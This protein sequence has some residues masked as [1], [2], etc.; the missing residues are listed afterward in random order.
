MGI[1]VS[2][3][4][5]TFNRVNFLEE[6][7]NSVLVQTLTNWEC[8]VVDDG[9]TDG[10][11][12][13][14]EV[15]LKRDSRFKYLQRPI[16]R[17]KG[18]SSCRNIGL[19]YSEGEFIQFLDSDDILSPN[20][21]QEQV[22]ALDKNEFNSIATCKWGYFRTSGKPLHAKEYRPTYI[23][24]DNPLKLFE[25][26]GKH[27]TFFPPHVFLVRKV[28][29]NESGYWN[30]DLTNNDDGEF[31]ARVLLSCSSIVFVPAAEAYYRIGSGNNLSSL[32]NEV[33]VRSL[34][35]SFEL[36][37]AAIIAKFGINNHLYLRQVKYGIFE[38]IKDTYP[39]IVLEKSI[40]FKTKFSRIEYYYTKLLSK[41]QVMYNENLKK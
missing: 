5:P 20:K 41:F 34:I 11:N 21:L 39:H 1:K 8:I 27:S 38:K 35:L 24:T 37:N 30:E 19:E 40:F 28:I 22:H 15:Y 25:V 33:K 26:Y 17:T 23:N 4:I 7:L 9:S 31:F 36:I 2:V 10:T 18:A 16:E 32:S 3:I 13:L 14:M 29:V 6:T 12:K